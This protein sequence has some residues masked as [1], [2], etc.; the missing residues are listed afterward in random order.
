[1]EREEVMEKYWRASVQGSESLF[2]MLQ[3]NY[4]ICLNIRAQTSGLLRHK[5][6]AQGLPGAQG[7]SSSA[8][9]P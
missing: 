1:M 9:Y 2:C 8:V 3:V 7:N 5:V 4:R 6:T